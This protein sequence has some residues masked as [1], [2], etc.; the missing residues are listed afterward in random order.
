M[1][2]YRVSPSL[3]PAGHLAALEKTIWQQYD[4]GYN[5]G[6]VAAQREAV[7]TVLNMVVQG[8]EAAA[9]GK[10]SSL[11]RRVSLP[12]LQQFGLLSCDACLAI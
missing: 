5:S 11:V 8:Q 9:A 6:V 7:H 1:V 12:F 4:A 3:V 2:R 10:E